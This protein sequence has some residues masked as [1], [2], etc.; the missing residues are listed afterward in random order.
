MIHFLKCVK[1]CVNVIKKKN[2][3]TEKQTNTSHKIIIIRKKKTN[4]NVIIDIKRFWV[5]VLLSSCWYFSMYRCPVATK[6][7]NQKKKNHNKERVKKM[8]ENKVNDNRE[9]KAGV[10]SRFSVF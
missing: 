7:K 5:N 4:N 3:R 2:A 9:F 10:F 1:F 8:Q 6:K